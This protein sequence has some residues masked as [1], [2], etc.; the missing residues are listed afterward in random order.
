MNR[1]KLLFLIFGMFLLIGSLGIVSAEKMWN[2]NNHTVNIS[3]DLHVG[4]IIYG[5]LDEVEN[6]GKFYK[7]E[8][9]V[10]IDMIPGNRNGLPDEFFSFCLEG[11]LNE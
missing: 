11:N 8:K 9:F 2:F 3:D 6:C 4:G 5:D 10:K 1:Q 7:L